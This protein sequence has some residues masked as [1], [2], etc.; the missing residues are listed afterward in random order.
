[1]QPAS[2]PS[3][4]EQRQLRS[5]NLTIDASVDSGFLSAYADGAVFNDTSNINWATSGIAVANYVVSAVSSAGKV[6]IRG[7]GA[8][9]THVII[10]VTGYYL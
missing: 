7:G 2:R 10:D 5:F 6:K 1:M 4:L 9:S 3:W 8:G